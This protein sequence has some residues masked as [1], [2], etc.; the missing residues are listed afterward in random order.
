MPSSTYGNS[1]ETLTTLLTSALSRAKII[2][3]AQETPS[4][5]TKFSP[6]HFLTVYGLIFP[7]RPINGLTVDTK[8]HHKG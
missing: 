8:P 4:N 5:T 7:E 6:D 2:R 3:E 1:A